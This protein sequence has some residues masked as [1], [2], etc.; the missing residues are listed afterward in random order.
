MSKKQ[1]K[2]E[3]QDSK[4]IIDRNKKKKQ[5]TIQPKLEILTPPSA[6]DKTVG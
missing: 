6:N 5:T 4:A 2:V 3:L 1:R